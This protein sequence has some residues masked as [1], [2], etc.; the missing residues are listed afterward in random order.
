[1]RTKMKFTITVDEALMRQLDRMVEQGKFASRSAALDLALHAVVDRQLNLPEERE[2]AELA[3]VALELGGQRYV[4][5]PR[6][7][8]TLLARTAR[9]AGVELRKGA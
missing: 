6:S 2:V 8:Y 5:L 4:V 7:E 9:K 1:M 3:P